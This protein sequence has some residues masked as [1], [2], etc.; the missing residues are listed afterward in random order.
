MKEI[1]LSEIDKLHIS[2]LENEF[3]KRKKVE[4]KYS[5][6]KY[7]EDA[8]IDPSTMSQYLRGK[9]K[10]TQEAFSLILGK[11]RCDE[12][13]LNKYQQD[14]Q[15]LELLKEKFA[16]IKSH[17][18]YY[19]ILELTHT[20]DFKADINWVANRLGISEEV[21]SKA[22]E[23]MKEIGAIE[24]NQNSWC[25]KLGHVTF[26]EEPDMDIEA[27]RIHQKQLLKLSESSIDNN[28]GAIKDHTSLCFAF[29]TALMPEVKERIA[30]F[31]EELTH[32]IESNSK[33]K[34]EVYSLQVNLNPLSHK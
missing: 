5:L 7:S 11:I 22:I 2:I 28:E 34:D 31:K 24:I 16:L 14:V 3:E 19:G 8:G 4:K 25:D 18:Y 27:G 1:S 21:V 30:K 10:L 6:R 20:I 9:R 29:D 12:E 15:K 17:W 26:V 23:D 13:T 33:N 32:Y